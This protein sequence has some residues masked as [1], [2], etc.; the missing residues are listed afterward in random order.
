MNDLPQNELLS[1]YLD[2]ELTAAEQAE[3][4][5]LLATS[6]AARQLLDELRALSTTLQSLPQQKVGEDLSPRV[7]RVAERRMLTG[8]EA[9]PREIAAEPPMPLGRSIYRRFTTPRILVRLALIAIVVVI[10]V[11]KRSV[12]SSRAGRRRGPGSCPCAGPV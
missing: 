12:A 4:E 3:M 8:E 2:G 9:G 11:I 1:A 7:L 5:R 6:P 10:I